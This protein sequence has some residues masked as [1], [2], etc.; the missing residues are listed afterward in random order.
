MVTAPVKPG[1]RYVILENRSRVTGIRVNCVSP[2]YTKTDFTHQAG[3]RTAEEAATSVVQIAINEEV[4]MT[5]GFFH[6][7]G[8]RLPW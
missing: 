3:N 8:T 1:I 4:G 7:D 2:G 5:S 6:E